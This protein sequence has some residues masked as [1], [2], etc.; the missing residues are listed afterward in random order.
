M[1]D[2]ILRVCKNCN[3]VKEIVLFQKIKKKDIYSYRHTCIECY[4]EHRKEYNKRFYENNKER[5]KN[6]YYKYEKKLKKDNKKED[7]KE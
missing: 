7:D 6:K 4:K 2:K 3:K 5:Y 1:T